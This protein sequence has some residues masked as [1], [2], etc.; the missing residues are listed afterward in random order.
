MPKR[1]Q[2]LSTKSATPKR[3]S[4]DAIAGARQSTTDDIEKTE[5]VPAWRPEPDDDADTR[6]IISAYA[7]VLAAKSGK[8]SG[9]KRPD[10]GAKRKAAAKSA[11]PIKWAKK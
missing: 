3:A 9:A 6:M 8:A 1:A 4:N 11:A 5:T 7:R 10:T 2:K